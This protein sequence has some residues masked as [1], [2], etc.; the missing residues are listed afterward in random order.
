MLAE[1]LPSAGKGHQFRRSRKANRG[2]RYLARQYLA[3]VVRLRRLNEKNQHAV[4]VEKLEHHLRSA[5]WVIRL[6][7]PNV[8]RLNPGSDRGLT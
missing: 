6:Y 8:A 2:E 7:R 1:V 4:H 3:Q 5:A